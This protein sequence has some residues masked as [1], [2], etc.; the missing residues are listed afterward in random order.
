MKVLDPGHKYKLQ[1]IDGTN[2]YHERALN[3]LQFVK[4]EGPGY[5]GNTGSYPGT[6]LQELWRAEIDRIKYLNNQIPCPENYDCIKHLRMC[7]YA[8]EIRAAKRHDK[9]FILPTIVDIESIPTCPKCG[10][11]FPHEHQESE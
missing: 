7:I 6:I 1:T 10:H 4:R 11:I 2:Q 9:V 3:I 5:P 8:L